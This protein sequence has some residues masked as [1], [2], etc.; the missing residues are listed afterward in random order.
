[1][2]RNDLYEYLLG[3][4]SELTKQLAEETANQK[5]FL[6]QPKRIKLDSSNFGDNNS[7]PDVMLE[8]IANHRKCLA[9]YDEAL[10]RFKEGTYGICVEC[11][12]DIPTSRL[13]VVPFTDLCVSCKS[14]RERINTVRI[15]P[16]STQR[17]S[18]M[19]AVVYA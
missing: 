13:L 15:S 1:M 5:E 9:K 19:G 16:F 10:E 11:E 3:K 2:E 7:S 18:R 4:R 17:I 8:R 14:E 12:E 6:R